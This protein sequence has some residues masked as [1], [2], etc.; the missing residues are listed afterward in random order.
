M[1]M[2]SIL[3][4]AFSSLFMAGYACDCN[5]SNI[6]HYTLADVVFVGKVVRINADRVV[7]GPERY[8]SPFNE[9]YYS[10]TLEVIEVSKGKWTTYKAR[11]LTV[12]IHSLALTECGIEYQNYKLFEVYAYYSKKDGGLWTHMCGGVGYLSEEEE[13]TRIE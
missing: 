6:D 13:L 10:V 2:R 8:K 11:E 12:R 3:T 4:I 9:G 7:H 5:S 1:T